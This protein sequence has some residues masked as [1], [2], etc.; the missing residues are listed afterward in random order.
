MWGLLSPPWRFGSG[1]GS[2]GATPGCCG[3]ANRM[4]PGDLCKAGVPGSYRP[5]PRAISPRTGRSP[6]ASS[7]GR[8]AGTR[9]ALPGPLVSGRQA[10]W[11]APPWT[12]RPPAALLVPDPRSLSG[13]G[14]PLSRPVGLLLP[15]LESPAAPGWLEVRAAVPWVVPVPPVPR[16]APRGSGR[17]RARLVGRPAGSARPADQVPRRESRRPRPAADAPKAAPVHALALPATD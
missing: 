13:G 5:D 15:G 7:F 3:D 10:C 9:L 14:F 1:Q 8:S 12:A 6:R 11:L 16:P 4:H 2:S 17:F